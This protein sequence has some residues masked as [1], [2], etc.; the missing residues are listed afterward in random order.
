[1]FSHYS[2]SLLPGQST[3]QSPATASLNELY[4]PSP[5]LCC[6]LLGVTLGQE[7]AGK[8]SLWCHRGGTGDSVAQAGHISLT[9]GMNSPGISL[10]NSSLH[11]PNYFLVNVSQVT[12]LQF[13]QQA[14]KSFCMAAGQAPKNQK[15]PNPSN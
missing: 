4:L 3:Q 9:S 2:H 12:L 1:M 14:A 15:K 11:G 6:S 5:G 13:L 8:E 7:Q 10:H